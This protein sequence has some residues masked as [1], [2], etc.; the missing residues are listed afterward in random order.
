MISTVYGENSHSLS[1]SIE[2]GTEP[3]V[4]AITQPDF[5]DCAYW[6]GMG[7]GSSPDPIT[8]KGVCS[9]K[10]ISNQAHLP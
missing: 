3:H 7:G 8:E 10:L 5:R 9:K 4:R 6:Q 2:R 1:T